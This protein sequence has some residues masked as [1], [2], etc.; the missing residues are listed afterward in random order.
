MQQITLRR[1]FEM[2]YDKQ[3]GLE[4]RALGLNALQEGQVRAFIR[5]ASPHRGRLVIP[6]SYWLLKTPEDFN[7]LNPSEKKIELIVS[8][9]LPELQRPLEE[10]VSWL[11]RE[12]DAPLTCREFDLWIQDSAGKSLESVSRTVVTKAFE[13]LIGSLCANVDNWFPVY[14]FKEEIDALIAQ[15][16]KR[17]AAKPGPE[18]QLADEPFWLELMRHMQV[19]AM[20]D[21]K[22][23]IVAK[24]RFW[25][26]KHGLDG[27]YSDNFVKRKVDAAY[28]ATQVYKNSRSRDII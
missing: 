28:S 20:D 2:L 6:Q 13:I 25:V 11:G 5:M 17:P 4:G 18:P 16:S 3:R 14:A 8:D 7:Y 12:N 26:S 22:P 19:M 27:T 15:R 9:L 1:A 10:M 23:D 21:K 24:M